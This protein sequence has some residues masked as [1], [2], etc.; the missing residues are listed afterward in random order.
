VRGCNG[1]SGHVLGG[2]GN[3]APST[4]P[5]SVLLSTFSIVGRDETGLLGVAVASRVIAVGARCPFVRAQRLAAASQ[6]YSNPYLSHDLDALLE[7]GVELEQAGPDAL[8]RDPGVGWRQFIAI[9]PTGKPFAYTGEETDSWSGHACGADC[10]AAGNLLMS[11]DTVDALVQTFE[12][13]SDED[14]PGRLLR[15]LAAGQSA[16]G[17][18]RGQQS[19]AVLVYASQD[20]PYV[21]LRVDDHE[22]PIAELQ[23]IWNALSSED[24][25]LAL[26]TATRREPRAA[27]EMRAR[28]RATRE[29]LRHDGVLVGEDD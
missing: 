13:G 15:A 8:E 1:E 17:D 18:R 22:L 25:A 24:R 20:V 28:Q 11:G 5:R 23:R 26:E 9:G 29:K 27:E 4:A 3:S 7:S 6:A 10:A 16:G 19:A 14:L 12:E 2:S 21:N